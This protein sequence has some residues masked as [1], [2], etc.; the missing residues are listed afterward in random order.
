MSRFARIVVPGIPHH[1]TQRGN[2]GMQ[3]FLDDEDRQT[4]LDLLREY[5]SRYKVYVWAYVLLPDHIHLVLVPINRQALGQAMRETHTAYAHYFNRKTQERGHLWQGRFSS[6]VL[7]ETSLWAAVRYLERNPLRR[8]IAS[9]PE[10]YPWS[11]AM[12]HA[13]LRDDILLSEGFPPKEVIR[14]WPGWLREEDA[15]GEEKIRRHT[16]TGRPCGGV[17]FVRKLERLLNRS[18]A[19]K[20]RG[21]KPGSKNKK[22]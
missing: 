2:R 22:G 12:G 1:V 21:R 14:D 8:A 18:M 6:C 13:G 5:C 9:R 4:Y 15:E 3:V 11:S 7:D 20:K 16:R 10:A 17:E 19:A